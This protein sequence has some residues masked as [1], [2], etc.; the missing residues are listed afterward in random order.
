MAVSLVR[1]LLLVSDT[2]ECTKADVREKTEHANEE[3]ESWK[4]KGKVSFRD[5]FGFSIQFSSSSHVCSDFIDD[6]TQ[7]V[8]TRT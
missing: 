4:E 5:T 2:A 7:D 6:E 8:R 1:K 3:G